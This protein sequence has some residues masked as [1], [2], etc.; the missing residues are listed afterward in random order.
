MEEL[1]LLTDEA[2]TGGGEGRQ[3]GLGF[4]AYA[5]VLASA[6]KGTDGPFTI[7]VFGEWGTGKT[8]LMRMVETMLK[9]EEHIIPVWFNA[10]RYE[11]EEH[12]IVPM[13]ATIIRSIERQTGK[14]KGRFDRFRPLVK[15]LRAVAYGFSAK[16][17]VQVPGFAEIEASFV[18]KDMIEREERL[19]SPDPLLDRSLYYEAF[20][21][22][23]NIDLAEEGGKV[24]LIIDDLDRCFP[25]VAI[26]LLESIKLV[27]AQPGFV[28]ILGIARQVIEGYLKKRYKEK[29][30]LR[31]F[32]GQEYLDKI[33]QLPFTIPP[34]RER[35]QAF[36][37]SLLEALSPDDRTELEQVLPM[38]GVACAYNPR[39]T[40][41]FV[42]NLLIDR[43]ISKSLK[44]EID[45]GYFAI[46]RSL[47]Q[48]WQR[49]L[50]RLTLPDSVQLCSQINQWLQGGDSPAI[51]DSEGVDA[52]IIRTLNRDQ[53]LQALLKTEHGINWLQEHEHRRAAL[54]FLHTQRADS[55]AEYDLESLLGQLRTG[56]KSEALNAYKQMRSKTVFHDGTL[57]F[58]RLESA[59]L[60]RA[61]LARA[62]LVGANLE[63]A[64][65]AGATL[66]GATLAG[67]TLAGA[68]LLGAI[69]LGADLA[70]A[71]LEGATLADADLARATLARAYLA[72]ATLAG[73]TLAG[74]TLADADLEGADLARANLAGADL[75][76]ANLAGARLS[77]FT[78]L[79]DSTYIEKTK[80]HTKHWTPETDMTKYSDPNH[81]EFWK[82][83][84]RKLMFTE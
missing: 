25:D 5:N 67:A 53:D 38:I 8:S 58:A 46:T 69:L 81:P 35:M 28:F 3:D 37:K 59:D 74:A 31:D 19:S 51:E 21:T 49:I 9:A 60:A 75:L 50:Q 26:R 47:Q 45:I 32:K 61:D 33:V 82:P 1:R 18:A 79:P 24:V 13:V 14:D 27:F 6:A 15:A 23:S 62:T 63:S 22:L 10:W 73:A 65:L 30:G 39:V 57:N 43:A 71:D 20:D 17:K 11:R 76:G 34:H 78:V 48:H 56:T 72:R 36:S 83:N 44:S 2:I 54:N 40:I 41:R 55:S 52:E 80:Q 16:S 4:S 66:A 77:E 29:Y 68:N 12:P 64:N 70:R 42:N 84:P 7:G